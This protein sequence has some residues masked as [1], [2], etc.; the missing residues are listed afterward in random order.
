MEV[1]ASYWTAEPKSQR[2]HRAHK[3]PGGHGVPRRLGE[4]HQGNFCV[5]GQLV[6]NS[7][8]ATETYKGG[9]AASDWR[10][11]QAVLRATFLLKKGIPW[12]IPFFVQRNPESTDE[13]LSHVRDW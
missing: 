13:K 3:F 10:P 12:E 2:I 8:H 6:M 7:C 4:G 11:F 5:Q 9:M 1:S